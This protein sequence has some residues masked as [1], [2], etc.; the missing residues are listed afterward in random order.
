MIPGQGDCG[1]INKRRGEFNNS[2]NI[3]N[4]FSPSLLMRW[5][6]KNSMFVDIAID[7]GDALGVLPTTSYKC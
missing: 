6:P 4:G 3:S 5:Y 2:L 1:G 7:D